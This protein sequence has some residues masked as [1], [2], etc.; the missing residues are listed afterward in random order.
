LRTSEKDRA[1]NILEACNI[2][3]SCVATDIFGVSGMAIMKALI[4]NPE[5]VDPEE[6]AQLAKGKLRD[7]IPELIEALTG[8]MD[9]HHAIMLQ[10]VL[11]HLMFLNEQLEELDKLL[12]EKCKPYQQEIQLL[13]TIPG[14]DKIS[15][16]A[17]V[18]EVGIDMSVF[19]TP[20]RLASW[21]GLS[22]GNNVSAGKKK[23][24]EQDQATNT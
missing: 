3:L 7:K 17:I 2:K 13:S 11:A 12:E 23:A 16:Q 9:K 19:E 14:V 8:R 1:H 5:E 18:A 4:E 6:L 21:A 24:Q 10:M 20:E 15:A 22:P